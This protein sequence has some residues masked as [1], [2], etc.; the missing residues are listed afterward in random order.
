MPRQPASSTLPG[1]ALLALLLAFAVVWFATLDYRKLIKPDE[2][3]YAEIARE[4]AVTGDW[5]TPRLNGI[6]YF[7]KPP[8]QYW[9]T[10]AAFKAFG[11]NEWTARLWGALTGFSG[12]LLAF[13]TGRALWGPR[14]GLLGAAALGSSALWVAIGHMNTLDMGLSFFLQLALSGLLLANRPAAATT[15]Q[16]RWMLVT[17]AAVALAVLSKGIVALVLCGGTLVV[18]SALC[19]D[20]GPWRRLHLGAGLPVFLAI[21][22]PW[23]IAVSLANPEFPRFFFIHEHFERFLTTTHRRVQPAWYF[24]PI[25]LGGA[26]PWT[27][28]GVQAA[29]AAWRR[30]G[31]ADFQ[32]GR[33]LVVWTV[34]VFAFFSASG[35]KLPSYI[36]PMLPATAM[37]AGLWLTT[38]SA[39]SLR[40]HCAIVALI[41][42]LALPFLIRV[43]DFGN[44]ETTRPMLAAYGQ[45]LVVAGGMLLAAATAAAW[46]AQRGRTL[47]APLALALGGLSCTTAVALGHES[48]ARSNSSYHLAMQV[49]P[50][51]TP[52]VPFYSVDM[53]DQTLPFYLQRTLT[54]VDY[55]DEMGFGLD[56]EPHLAV[57]TVAAFET[58]WRA[59]ADAFALMSPD[60]HA[61]LDAAGL[62]MRVVARDTRRVI[63]RTL[64]K[65]P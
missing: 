12:V 19:R 21:A 11:E 37:L 64:P 32:P 3:R 46:L 49:R 1:G 29:V 44:V 4:M 20:L 15:A 14:A 2:G 33:L 10:A 50:L 18:Y 7:E 25:F 34:F 53:Y 61:K 52:N 57:P 39:G 38:A 30:E 28:I 47:A 55:R 36:R 65:T 42:A 24:L 5:V 40:N 54:L 17:W 43:G 6:K 16:R 58:R 56:Q 51:L 22:A 26:L 9:A 59:A 13:F 35:S 60:T 48:L 45:W 31:R 8:L 41:A 27:L 63:A 62:P 23:F